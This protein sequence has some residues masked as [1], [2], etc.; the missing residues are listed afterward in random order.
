MMTLSTIISQPVWILVTLIGLADFLIFLWCIILIRRNR[1]SQNGAEEAE[2]FEFLPEP[3]AQPAVFQQ[4]LTCMQIDAVFDGLV[5]LIET[6]RVKLKTMMHP[7][8][9]PTM[10]E[11]AS[12]PDPPD[13]Q[14]D[15][16]ESTLD[17][18]Q[19]P[20]PALTLDEQI[21]R[22]AASGKKPAAIAIQLGISLAEV[23]L[24]MRMHA[25]ERSLAGHKLEAVA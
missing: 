12:P 1:N 7:M 5:A 16:N 4:N 25:G 2:D 3:A 19:R 17:F 21:T 20:A 9:A 6:E 11:P 15:V 23:N 14:V 18:S 24:A 13:D 10:P 8:T 22:F